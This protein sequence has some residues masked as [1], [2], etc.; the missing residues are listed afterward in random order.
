MIM[1]T[2]LDQ[3]RGKRVHFIGI[4]GAGMSGIAKIMLSQGIEVSGSD[5]KESTVTE[6]LRTMGAKIF[7]G[8]KAENV[9]GVDLLVLSTAIAADNPERA[10]AC[11]LYTSDAAD[12]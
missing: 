8:H 1:P 2:T 6:N 10:A 9:E 11:L 5:L 4:G 7:I 12:E 3:L